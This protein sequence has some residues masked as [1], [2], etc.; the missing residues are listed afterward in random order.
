MSLSALHSPGRVINEEDDHTR[1][2]AP[3]DRT[4]DIGRGKGGNESLPKVSQPRVRGRGEHHPRQEVVVEAPR[5]VVGTT[6]GPLGGFGALC[7]FRLFWGRITAL[8]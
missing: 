5:V 2:D 4:N 7:A 3:V 1:L 6:S 8:P